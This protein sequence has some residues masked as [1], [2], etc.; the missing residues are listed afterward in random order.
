MNSFSENSHWKRDQHLFGPGPKRI[1]ALD[2]GGVRG[3]ISV[4]FLERM[5]T[6]LRQQTGPKSSLG[7]WFDLI[8]GTSTGAIIAGGV[9]LGFN[10][11]QLEEFYRLRAHRVF[12]RSFGRIPGIRSR[13]DA[14][15]L[16]AEI[17]LVVGNRTL[18][19]PD[20]TTGFAL[21][22]KRIDTGSPWIIANNP[23]STYWDT[24]LNH[25]FI[26]NRHYKLSNLV[27]ASTA[28]PFYFD[29]EV[30]TIHDSEPNGLFIDGGVTPHNNP[31]FALFQLATLQA[32]KLCWPTGVDKLT[33]I[34]IGTGTHRRRLSTADLG[35]MAPI[36]L[37]YHALS[38]LAEDAET[39][40]LGLMQW[41][42]DSPAPW[43]IN[44]EVGTLSGEM[45]PCGPLFKFVRYDV[46]LEADW[47]KNNF[48]RKLTEEQIIGLREM[49]NPVN[50]A[51][52][53]DIGRQAAAT[54][55]KPEHFGL[56]PCTRPSPQSY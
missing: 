24:P 14:K 40:V 33:I 11:S 54:Q 41:L 25:N 32:H 34:S 47:L 5:E 39:H 21:V 53:Y 45:L 55:V 20:L 22:T 48:D 10:T 6:I 36:K 52:A 7:D 4:A 23:R 51:L 43:P 12:R 3:A 15:M 38:S 31:S 13:F 49:D 30:I 17:E 37:A 28:A 16:S 18:D 1:L 29:P 42:G 26:G 56:D 27:R 8:G 2:G 46:R 9:A 19:T 44:G 35:F 50:I